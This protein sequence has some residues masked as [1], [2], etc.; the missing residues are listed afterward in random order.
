MN[1]KKRNNFCY[2]YLLFSALFLI[3]SPTYA[4]FED[5]LNSARAAAMGE[6]FVGLANSSQAIFINPAG[7]TGLNS[8]EFS[9]FYYRPYGIK[10]LTYTTL[11]LTHPFRNFVP[12]LAI[13]QYGY[14][15]Y[16]ETSINLTLSKA[17]RQI[18]SY[19]ATCRFMHLNI[20]NYG[21]STTVGFDLGLIIHANTKT[22]F[23]FVIK[24]LNQPQ[25]GQSKENIPPIL[26]S[27]VY[28]K[29]FRPLN[30]VFDV[31]KHFDFPVDL[32][33][34]L[35]YELS[36]FIILRGGV[37]SEPS[38]F[39]LGVGLKFHSVITDYAFVS[40]P[41]LNLT[42]LVSISFSRPLKN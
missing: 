33:T 42:H 18:F 3:Y 1:L 2:N 32:R 21:S 9:S 37:A 4:S 17:F 13:Q 39:S 31:Y 5:L 34:G 14:S 29:V 25:I 16:H 15:N 28:I 11:T 10:E 38:R 22:S 23:G 36:R 24:N 19:G 20:K 30:L 6:A 26:V 12:G 41:T 7:L 8:L 27:G 40:H 35:E